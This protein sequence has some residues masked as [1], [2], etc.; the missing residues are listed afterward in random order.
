[1]TR[2]ERRQRTDDG[3]RGKDSLSPQYSRFSLRGKPQVKWPS[4]FTG[5]AELAEPQR[6]LSHRGS[7]PTNADSHGED[8]G[9]MAFE[10]H[11]AGLS[12][13]PRSCPPGMSWK[14]RISIGGC[15][16]NGR[17]HPWKEQ[18]PNRRACISHPSTVVPPSVSYTHLR[19]HET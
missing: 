17:W 19:A 10:F 9:E 11:G 14:L 4:N 13:C 1:M 8:P 18:R 7:T 5:R 12:P 3:R 6:F 15:I 2:I 16:G